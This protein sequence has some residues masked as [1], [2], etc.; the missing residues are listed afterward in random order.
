MKLSRYRE[1]IDYA[2]GKASDGIRALLLGGLA[3]VWTFR[4]TTKDGHPRLPLPLFLAAFFLALAVVCDV[5]QYV[6]TVLTYRS[7]YE[8]EIKPTLKPAA[9]GQDPDD[10]TV[11]A[12]V[13]L[14]GYGDAFFWLRFVS[15]GAGLLAVLSYAGCRLG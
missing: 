6:S 15:A 2:S 13:S 14:R 11:K 5:L 3:L 8:K 1:I 10:R 7:H 9:E 4:D 12:P